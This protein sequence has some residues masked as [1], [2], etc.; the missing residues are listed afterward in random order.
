[1]WV[2]KCHVCH[3]NVYVKVLVRMGWEVE[4]M[5][6]HGEKRSWKRWKMEQMW[7]WMSMKVCDHDHAHDQ[8][9]M[10]LAPV[11]DHVHFHSYVHLI[12][13]QLYVY[14]PMNHSYCFGYHHDHDGMWMCGYGM[15]DD[16]F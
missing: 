12:H 16:Q 1:M 4:R 9:V 15:Y 8:F 7:M 14:D 6:Y 3:G 10:I 11:V 2:R 13:D 5:D